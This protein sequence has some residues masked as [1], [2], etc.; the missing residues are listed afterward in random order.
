MDDRR[1]DELL[2]YLSANT[3]GMANHCIWKAEL[4]GLLIEV[5]R[6]RDRPLHCPCCDGDHL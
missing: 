5:K 6:Q 1:V 3:D 2:D 4:A